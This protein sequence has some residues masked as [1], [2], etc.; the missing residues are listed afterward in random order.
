MAGGGAADEID[1]AI[2]QQATCAAPFP[3]V[4]NIGARMPVIRKR[5]IEIHAGD[6][7]LLGPGAGH[8]ASHQRQAVIVYG[9]K[10]V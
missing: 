8:G 6:G 3:V 5:V 10:V 7:R 9:L 4:G 2:V 1:L